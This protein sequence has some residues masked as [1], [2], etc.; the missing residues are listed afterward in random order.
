MKAIYRMDIISNHEY[1]PSFLPV[2]SFYFLLTQILHPTAKNPHDCNLI[3]LVSLQFMHRLQLLC[4]ART[5]K[6]RVPASSGIQGRWRCH[7]KYF[8]GYK[9]ADPKLTMYLF[10][11]TVDDP[12]TTLIFTF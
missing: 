1:R 11:D 8:E 9:D 5:F 4:D 10:M 6:H 12:S 3:R 2:V 7:T